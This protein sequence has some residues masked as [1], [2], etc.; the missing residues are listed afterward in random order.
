MI[1]KNIYRNSLAALSSAI[2]L[3]GCSAQGDNPGVEYA[4]QMYHS[5]SYEPLSQITDE[6]AG[7][8]LSNREDGKGEFYNSNIYNP[9]KQN[10]RL[11]AANTVRRDVPLPY[12]VHK[13]SVDYAGRHVKSPIPASQEV[14][15]EGQALYNRFCSQCHGN[16]GQGDGKV[17]MVFKGVPSYSV[18]RV[19]EVSEGHIFHV[20]TYGRGRMGAHGSQLDINER[21]KIV[22]YVQTLQ[23]QN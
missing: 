1:L 21:W 4:P 12:R 17:G 18:G 23:K 22:R 19:A 3:A 20:I 10:V 5:V 15:K 16:T 11:P 13:D 7:K 6:N 9:N 14:L 8:W 2:I